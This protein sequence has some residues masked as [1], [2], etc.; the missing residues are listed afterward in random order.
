VKSDRCTPADIKPVAEV[1]SRN[2]DPLAHYHIYDLFGIR[3]VKKYS[4]L[5]DRG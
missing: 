2:L 5:K 1:G 4:R 3:D